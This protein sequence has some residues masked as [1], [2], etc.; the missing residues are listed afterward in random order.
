VRPGELVAQLDDDHDFAVAIPESTVSNLFAFLVEARF[1]G[2]PNYGVSEV[3]TQ[4]AEILF[5]SKN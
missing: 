2:D 4:I 3:V 5:S 1:S